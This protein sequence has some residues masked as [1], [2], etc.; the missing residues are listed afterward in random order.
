MGLTTARGATDDYAGGVVSRDGVDIT[1]FRALTLVARQ[2]TVVVEHR[3]QTES[4]IS[5]PEFE[6][7]SALAAAPDHRARAGALGQMLAWEKSRISHQVG[8]MERKGLIKRFSC[9]D[10][11][12][13]TWV[14][15]TEAGADAIA[16]ATPAYEGAIEAQ[17]G[18]FAAAEDGARLA[19]EVLSIGSLVTSESCQREVAELS[20]S[21][22]LLDKR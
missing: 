3:L 10:D 18:A 8:R 9:A 11:M 12:R 7:L 13:G 16:S 15:L 5:L 14:G 4:G 2:L 1:L 22:R 20:D 6:I 19:H 21:L 17:L